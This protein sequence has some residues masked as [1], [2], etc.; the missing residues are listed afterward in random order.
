VFK[1]NKI[2]CLGFPVEDAMSNCKG[3]QNLK[4]PKM[5]KDETRIGIGLSSGQY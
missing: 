1:T 4:E 2:F 5:Y 3:N